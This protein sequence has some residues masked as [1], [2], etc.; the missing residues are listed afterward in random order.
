MRKFN[1]HFAIPE[2]ILFC[3]M[4]TSARATIQTPVALGSNST[5]VALAGTTVT[6]TGGGSITGNI[7]ISPGSAFVPGVP[8]VTVQGTV[9]AGGPVA[10]Q[11]QADL[12]LAF[13]DA[14]GRQ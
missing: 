14:A 13:N 4:A 3:T 12:T 8:A 11:A 5:F 10:A 9:Y 6:I 2:L 7:G 1:R